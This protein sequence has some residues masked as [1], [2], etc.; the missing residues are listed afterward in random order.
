MVRQFQD[1]YFDGRLQSTIYSNPN[2]VEIAKAYGIPAYNL[3]VIKDAEAV[4][5]AALKIVGPVL[6]EV[7]LEQKT[8]VNPKLVVNRPIEDMYPHL[9]RDELKRIMLIDLVEEMEVP[10]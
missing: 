10:K 3:N 6:V 8:T 9:E 1:I 5:T 7:R 4:I 2:F